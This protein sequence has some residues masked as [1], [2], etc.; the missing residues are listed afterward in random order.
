[1]MQN[2]NIDAGI[3]SILRGVFGYRADR[4]S[5]S[6]LNKLA[7]GLPISSTSTNEEDGVKGN[8]GMIQSALKRGCGTQE[9]LYLE[10]KY[11]LYKVPCVC[12]NACCSGYKTSQTYTSLLATMVEYLGEYIYRP[13]GVKAS[14]DDMIVQIHNIRQLRSTTKWLHAMLLLKFLGKPN[15]L[16]YIARESK[17]DATTVASHRKKINPYLSNLED[18]ALEQ[19]AG[20]LTTL[21]LIGG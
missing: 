3:D 17:V 20:V 5:G 12:G 6:T 7:S 1:M 10:L 15:K 19:A 14:V 8:N 21:G 18:R 2:H 11:S 9:M 13:E 16:A 4:V